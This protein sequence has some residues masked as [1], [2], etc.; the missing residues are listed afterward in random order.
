MEN[1]QQNQIPYQLIF[2]EM[3][4]MLSPEE[5]KELEQ[6]KAASP[7]NLAAYYA[8]RDAE[9]KLALL[10]LYKKTDIDHAWNKISSRVYG[11][12]NVPAIR[13]KRGLM[14]VLGGLAAAAAIIGVFAIAFNWFSPGEQMIYRTSENERRQI[15]LP[16]GS[17]VFLN[18]NSALSYERSS[19]RKKRHLKLLE[20][21]AYFIVAHEENNEFLVD[22]DEVIVRDIGTS[23]DLKIEDDRIKVIVNSGYVSMESR[24]HE[25]SQKVVLAANHQGIFDRETKNISSTTN[26]PANYKAWQDKKLRYVQT[27]LAEVVKDLKQF[28]GTQVVF[29]DTT[30]KSRTISTYLNLDQKTEDQILQIIA[31]T[32][33]LKVVKKDSTFVL[34]Q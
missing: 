31:A 32:L 2:D 13:K 8:L 26:V 15:P 22:M 10:D 4:R 14:F 28:Y 33:Q 30:L 12:N 3:E 9:G 16:D 29:Q 11:E 27:P 5:M 17:Q 23:F 18:E 34:F 19:F 7:E 6:W 25:L 24:K 1:Y 20:G 21:E